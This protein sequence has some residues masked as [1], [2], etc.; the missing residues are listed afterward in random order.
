MV[1]QAC[2]NWCRISEFPIVRKL[3]HGARSQACQQD[4]L[5]RAADVQR[6]PAGKQFA[7]EARARLTEAPAESVAEPGAAEAAQ[8]PAVQPAR[9]LRDVVDY[10]FEKPA[11][12]RKYSCQDY[13][14]SENVRSKMK[15]F[16]FEGAGFKFQKIY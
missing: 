1:L 12:Y 2:G 10:W 4:R 16:T 6:A 8:D 7:A 5:F 11:D 13:S 3:C 15:I 9:D 14:V